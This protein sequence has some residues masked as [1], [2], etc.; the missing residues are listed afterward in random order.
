MV[1]KRS[2][3]VGCC[4]S[5]AVCACKGE[6]CERTKILPKEHQHNQSMGIVANA[7]KRKAAVPQKSGDSC[8]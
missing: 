5:S 4:I 1:V 7:A 3:Q 2:A 8:Q 6:V